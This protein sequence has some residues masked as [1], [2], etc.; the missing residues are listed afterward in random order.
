MQAIKRIGTSRWYAGFKYLFLGTHLTFT[1][2]PVVP[3]E[4]VKKHEYKSIVSEA[5]VIV[6]LDS[7][8]NVFTP[9][10]GIKLHVD[11]MLS[12]N[13]LG[14]DYN[15]SQVNYYSYVYKKISRKLTGGWRVDG[16]QAFGDIPF[17]LLPYIN[18]RGVQAARYQGQI[19]LLTEGEI[20]YDVVPRWSVMMYGGTGK[21]F[22][23]WNDT[24]SA[25]WIYSYGSGFRY[26]LAR[27]FKLRVGLDVAKG[28]DRWA[29]YIVFG[30]N[31]AK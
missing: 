15:F 16:A 12:N 10:N 31:W 21:A 11:Y 25:P 30:S 29:Y 20:R 7:R 4:F 18:L 22:N 26:L 24:G 17:F 14:S 2:N 13:A 23:E 5:G 6:E 3:P 9:D 8:D 19:N 27:K 1:G 28:P